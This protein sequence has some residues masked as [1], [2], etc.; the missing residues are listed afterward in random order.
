MPMDGRVKGLSP[1]NTS[2]GSGVTFV[3]A[4][5]NG[6]SLFT[7]NKTIK[8]PTFIFDSKQNHLHGVL[9]LNVH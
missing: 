1:Q 7:Q 4:E 2:G 3:R 6:E 5:V 8:C 9:S